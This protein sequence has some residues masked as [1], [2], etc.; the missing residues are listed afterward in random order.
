MSYSII[1][2]YREKPKTKIKRYA[3]LSDNIVECLDTI[4]E[5]SKNNVLVEA[6]IQNEK[7]VVD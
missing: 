2:W 6:I 3:V 7:V 4:K 5:F 1:I